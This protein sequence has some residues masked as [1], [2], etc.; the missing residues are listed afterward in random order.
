MITL[1]MEHVDNDHWDDEE[2]F[3]GRCDDDDNNDEQ[4]E[5]T[6]DSTIIE[7][8]MNNMNIFVNIN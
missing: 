4:K 7:M 6:C 5:N 8:K 2:E 1:K 3:D